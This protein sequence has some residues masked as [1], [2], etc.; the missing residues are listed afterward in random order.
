MDE[1]NVRALRFWVKR[2]ACRVIRSLRA[3][4]EQEVAGRFFAH[5]KDFCSHQKEGYAQK[6]TKVQALQKAGLWRRWHELAE[7]RKILRQGWRAFHCLH[8]LRQRQYGATSVIQTRRMKNACGSLRRHALRNQE[9]RRLRGRANLFAKCRIEKTC[10]RAWIELAIAGKRKRLMGDLARQ[11]VLQ[12]RL[13]FKLRR[14]LE[15]ASERKTLTCAGIVAKEFRLGKVVP[16]LLTNWRSWAVNRVSKKARQRDAYRQHQDSLRRGAARLILT[17]ERE[18]MLARAA[19]AK[20][21]AWESLKLLHRCFSAWKK[22]RSTLSLELIAQKYGGG[23]GSVSN[24]PTGVEIQAPP[25]R[26]TSE[27]LHTEMKGRN[28]FSAEAAAQGD[29]QHDALQSFPDDQMR[30]PAMHAVATTQSVS[31]S[32]MSQLFECL[33]YAA[34]AQGHRNLGAAHL[35]SQEGGNPGGGPAY[36]YMQEPQGDVQMQ[37]DE[38]SLVVSPAGGFD[39]SLLIGAVSTPEKELPEVAHSKNSSNCVEHNG[40]NETL[41]TAET[42]TE[43]AANGRRLEATVQPGQQRVELLPSTAA[44]TASAAAIVEQENKGKRPTDHSERSFDRTTA[45]PFPGRTSSPYT[46]TTAPSTAR[47]ALL[48]DE[49]EEH[50]VPFADEVRSVPSVV[51]ESHESAM[52]NVGLFWKAQSRA[53]QLQQLLPGTGC[54]EF[55]GRTTFGTTVRK[56]RPAP[57]IPPCILR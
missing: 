8:A 54:K 34:Q 22:T 14:W 39:G 37:V 52:S 35:P 41:L 51:R 20:E 5:W 4:L 24:M 57:R 43:S 31:S 19:A 6:A 29:H 30:F 49:R 53:K 42:V 25:A 16:P 9:E 10:I 36:D 33:S 13:R 50:G 1:L 48:L 12:C 2:I 18:D 46:S 3:N 11:H 27:F 32:P 38:S 7:R 55:H 21:R 44:A 47:P 15:R 40:A 26:E 23:M 56:Q 45:S 28:L 17:R